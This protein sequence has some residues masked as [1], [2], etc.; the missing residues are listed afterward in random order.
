MGYRRGGLYSYD[1]L[2][3]LFGYLDAPSADRILPE[4]QLLAA[5]DEIPIG[6]GGGLPVRAIEPFVSW[7]SVRPTRK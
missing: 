6:R 5:G 1:W 2:D 4:W 7:C 3:R